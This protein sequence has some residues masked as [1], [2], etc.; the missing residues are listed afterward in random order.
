MSDYGE[1]LS[2]FLDGELPEEEAREIE[3]A[4]AN[5]PALQAELEELME[6]DVFAKSEFDAM[7][8]DPVPFELAAA[9]NAAPTSQ[10]ANTTTAPTGRAK[11][12]A[13]SAVAIALGLGGMG[14]YFFGTS[15]PSQI[16]SARGWLDDIADYHAVYAAQKRHLVEVPADEADHIEAWLT[17]TVGTDIKIPDLSAQG[18]Q[19]EGARLLVAAGKPVAQLV[20]RDADQKVVAL[21]AI[22]TATPQAEPGSKLAGAFEMVTWG[23]TDANFVIVGDTGRADLSEIAQAAA[24]QI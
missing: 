16:A 1:R 3:A 20:F 10:P 14:G 5:D 11:W 22:K 2:A 23:D 17:A 9:I 6:A 19:F 24:A 21:C 4:L 8:D 13:A 18:L 12:L 7:L 15:Q